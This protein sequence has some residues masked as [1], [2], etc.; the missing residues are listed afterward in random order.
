MTNLTKIQS[1]EAFDEIQLKHEQVL[2]DRQY[3]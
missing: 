1:A 3:V 2:K